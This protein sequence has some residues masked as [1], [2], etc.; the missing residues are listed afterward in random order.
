MLKAVKMASV[1][2]AVRMCVCVCVCFSVFH[3]DQRG[4]YGGPFS[5]S[6]LYLLLVQLVKTIYVNH[7]W[8]RSEAIVKRCFF[9]KM[10][11][12]Y[13]EEK[14]T[15]RQPVSFCGSFLITSY[16]LQPALRRIGF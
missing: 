15:F 9:Y 12:S 5:N 1:R 4:R 14:I 3:C 8:D 11:R 7:C 2:G 6:G 16:V 13:S 10:D